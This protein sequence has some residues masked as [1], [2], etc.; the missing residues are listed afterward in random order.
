MSSANKFFRRLILFLLP[1]TIVLY[2]TEVQLRKI[3]N[4]YSKKKL[5]LEKEISNAEVLVLGSSQALHGIDPTY[6]SIKG[7]NAANISQSLYYDK[8]ILKT[9]IY[10]AN[11]L[12][13]LIITLSYFTYFYEIHNS[14]ESWRDLYY[15]KF[16]KLNTN[17][18]ITKWDAK[19][20]SY[21]ALYTPLKT[22]KYATSNFNVDLAP[23]LK[24]NGYIPLLNKKSIEFIS[25][26]EGKK[27]VSLHNSIIK[28]DNFEHTISYL[29][30]MI[31]IAKTKKIEVV[32]VTPPVYKTYYENC[33]EKLVMANDHLTQSISNFNNI[34]YFDYLKDKRFDKNDF[35]D[36]DHL[37]MQGAKK[38][39]S[40][41]NSEILK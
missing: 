19:N 37:N 21:I 24:T 32:I 4:S 29:N 13:Y 6:F 18:E 30:E 17:T 5:N 34:K 36:N 22:A 2:Y 10:N 26:Q 14:L 20:Y 25:D 11:K 3:P 35:Y 12:K 27:R 33:N 28:I 16:W 31:E 41:I 40:I 7:I 1:V 15:Q 8:E 23:T 39:S 38:F 9:E